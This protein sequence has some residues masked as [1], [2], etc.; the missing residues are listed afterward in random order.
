[1]AALPLSIA[2]KIER[3]MEQ[4]VNPLKNKY[5]SLCTETDK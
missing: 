1:M 4:M 2:A 3:E 5:A